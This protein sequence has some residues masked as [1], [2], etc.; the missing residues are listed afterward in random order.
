VSL[1]VQD[2]KNGTL[3]TSPSVVSG[4]P[5]AT[6]GSKKGPSLLNARYFVGTGLEFMVVNIYAQ[7][8]QAISNDTY[9]LQAGVKAFW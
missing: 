4:T 7:F 5:E 9:G 6:L 8:T 2:I 1:F 3:T